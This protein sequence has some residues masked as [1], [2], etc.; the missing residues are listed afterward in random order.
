MDLLDGQFRLLDILPSPRTSEKLVCRIHHCYF[1]DHPTYA[2]ISYAWGDRRDTA[3]ISLITRSDFATNHAECK[4]ITVTSSLRDALMAL[5]HPKKRVK[6]WVDALSI[7]QSNVDELS[8]QVQNMDRIYQNATRVAIWLGPSSHNSALAITTLRQIGAD[9]DFLGTASNIRTLATSTPREAIAAIVDLF[10][11]NYWKRLWVVQEVF[12]AQ[13]TVLYCGNERVGWDEILQAITLF[14]TPQWKQAINEIYSPGSNLGRGSQSQYSFAQVLA[15]QG[16]Q[17]L[18]HRQTIH[19]M[20]APITIM[21]QTR[22]KLAARPQ[23]KVL[24]VLS[25]LGENIRSSLP[26]DFTLIPKEAFAE[27]VTSIIRDTGSLD[28]ICEAIRYPFHQDVFA[29][30]SWVADWSHVPDVSSLAATILDHR[31]PFKAS[32]DLKWEGWETKNR[33]GVSTQSRDDLPIDIFPLG[34]VTARGMAVGTLGRLN[35]Y[36]MAFLEWRHLFMDKFGDEEKNL[37]QAFCRTLCLGDVPSSIDLGFGSRTLEDEEWAV[38]SYFLFATFLSKRLGGIPLDQ[39]LQS[40]C[41]LEY[42]MKQSRAREVVQRYFGDRM[43]GRCFC[44]LGGEETSKRIGMGT[45]YIGIGDLVAVAHGC[46]T[47]IVLRPTDQGKYVFVG[48]IYVDGYMDG[49][50]IYELRFVKGL[51]VVLC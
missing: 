16:P 8:R 30:P 18:L 36:L 29:L 40:H 7:D 43:M 20:P 48:D 32:R 11:R 13:I 28:I 39:T 47:P 26:P 17:S 19:Q 23:D 6:V 50:A 10:E 46:S 31:G 5:R 38:I 3:K 35:N 49:E 14:G 33:S 1:H 21:R 25:L 44:V 27:V 22:S 41:K 42:E 9:T 4:V 34:T 51:N 37:R 12:Y 15:T 24:G 2:A 45:G